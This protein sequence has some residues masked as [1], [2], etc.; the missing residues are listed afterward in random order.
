[1]AALDHLRRV[2]ACAG[3][4]LGWAGTRG[5]AVAA[6]CNLAQ[7][8]QEA[9]QELGNACCELHEPVAPNRHENQ[10]AAP[11]YLLSCVTQAKLSR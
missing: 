6:K 5:S 11:A 10:A 2:V 3:V 7:V 8:G 9:G 4:D 1:M